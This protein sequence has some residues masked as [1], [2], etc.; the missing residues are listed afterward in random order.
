LNEGTACQFA[1]GGYI[2]FDIGFTNIML[3]YSNQPFAIDTLEVFTVQPVEPVPEPA[4]LRLMGTGLVVMGY[5]RSRGTNS[6]TT[7]EHLH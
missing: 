5:F 1:Y 3:G 4:S 6:M 7:F 2:P